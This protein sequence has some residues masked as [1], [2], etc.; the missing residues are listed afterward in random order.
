LHRPQ[1]PH[2]IAGTK[3]RRKKRQSLYVIP[4]RVADQEVDLQL[5]FGPIRQLIAQ[6]P[7]SSSC[8]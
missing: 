2:L 4:M 1:N 7:Y 5:T 3:E 8:V 6:Q